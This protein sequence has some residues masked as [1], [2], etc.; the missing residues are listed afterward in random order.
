MSVDAVQL[1]CRVC[2]GVWVPLEVHLG[3]PL[4]SVGLCKAVCDLATERMIFDAEG[5]ELHL[6]SQRKR[7][8]IVDGL[9]GSFGGGWGGAGSLAG[10]VP[11]TNFMFDGA[12]VSHADF[13]WYVQGTGV[14]KPRNNLSLSSKPSIAVG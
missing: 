14:G 3:L 8:A 1:T 9:R 4:N 10:S 5:R 7:A 6:K 12:K 13:S 11:A 2:A